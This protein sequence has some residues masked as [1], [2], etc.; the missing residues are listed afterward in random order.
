M[1]LLLLIWA[2]TTTISMVLLALR[3]IHLLNVQRKIEWIMVNQGKQLDIVMKEKNEVMEIIANQ[4]AHIKRIESVN[5][6]LTII[7][8]REGWELGFSTHSE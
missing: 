4:A 5:D 7:A 2:W 8:I 1:K 6:E 3:V